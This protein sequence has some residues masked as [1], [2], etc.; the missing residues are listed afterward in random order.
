[1]QNKS[2]RELV[3]YFKLTVPPDYTSE[4]RRIYDEPTYLG[5]KLLFHFND[6]MSPLLNLSDAN[7][8]KGFSAYNYLVS[9]GYNNQAFYLKNF[10][11]QLQYISQNSEWYFQGIDGLDNIWNF[12][13]SL[14]YDWS[15]YNTV[16]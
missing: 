15:S 2:F 1:M 4:I 3:S 16:H 13:F 11:N 7:N 14:C 8:D 10:I 6:S 5:F 12:D 9:N